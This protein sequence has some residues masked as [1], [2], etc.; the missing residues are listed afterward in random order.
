MVMKGYVWLCMA[1]YGYLGL[2]NHYMMLTP[3][4]YRSNGA[5]RAE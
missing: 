3:G 2:C 1:M 4:T 5:N